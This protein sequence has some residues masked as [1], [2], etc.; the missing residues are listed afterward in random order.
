VFHINEIPSDWVAI[1]SVRDYRKRKTSTYGKFWIH[2]T[3]TK[4]NKYCSDI[5]PE[6]WTKGRKIEY[7]QRSVD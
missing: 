1:N 2:N 4:E 5:I 3:T 7:Y 6:G